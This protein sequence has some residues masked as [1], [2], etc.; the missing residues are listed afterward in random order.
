ML[1]VLSSVRG[2]LV[3][4]APLNDLFTRLVFFLVLSLTLLA[5]VYLNYSSRCYPP[6]TIPCRS[7]N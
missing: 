2:L 6:V 1:S 7:L 3:P 5:H 4:P